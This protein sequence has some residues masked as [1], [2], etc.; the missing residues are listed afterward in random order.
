MKLKI[1]GDVASTYV[2]TI[3]EAAG[4]CNISEKLY[5]YPLS[6]NNT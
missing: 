4:Y 5:F 2:E 3:K 6:V 1:K